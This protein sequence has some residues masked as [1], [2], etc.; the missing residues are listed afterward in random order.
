MSAIQVNKDNFQEVVLNSDKPVLVDFW[1]SWCGPC[2][3]VA[4]V[5]EEIA[6]ERSDVKVCKIN[7]DE[8]PELAGRYNVMSIPT[9]LVVK[10]GQVVNQAVGARPK[11]QILSLLEVSKILSAKSVRG[12]YFDG[13]PGGTG[14]SLACIMKKTERGGAMKPR[15]K[16]I[17][18][19]LLFAL[20]GALAGYVYYFFFGCTKGC[21]ITGSPWRSMLYMAVL[22]LFIAFAS[23]KEG[24]GQCNT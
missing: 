3:M 15:S 22:G 13:P 8:E 7:V 17:L 5:L 11:S 1:A 19:L 23:E 18:R 24:D 21:A 14:R 16:R 9:L 20:G 12:E 4:P 2:R 6:N 10:E